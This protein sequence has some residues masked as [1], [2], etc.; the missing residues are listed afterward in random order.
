MP[1]PEEKQTPRSRPVNRRKFMAS[2]G[3]LGAAASL[4]PL[5]ALA[6]SATPEPK[7]ANGVMK[8]QPYLQQPGKD[9][10][11]VRWVTHTRCFSWVEYGQS[12]DKLDQKAVQ[13]E[14]GL[15]QADN[16]IHAITLTGLQPGKT[17]YYRAHSTAVKSLVRRKVNLGDT[18][19]S[20]V[21]SFTTLPLKQDQVALLVFNDIHDR[22][23]SFGHLMQFQEGGKKDFVLLNGD[24]FN[25][26]ESEDQVINHLLVP[27]TQQFAS[28]TPFYF[29]RGNHELHG[30]FSRQLPDY[31]DGQEHKFYYSVQ[32]GPVYALI[33]DSGESKE[34]DNEVHGGIIQ[35]FDAY[36]EAQA[37]WLAQE[38]QKKAFKEAKYRIVFVHHPLYHMNEDI[39]ANLHCRK[40]WG[41]T[42]NK[43][44]IDLM[45]SGH[46]HKAG[47]HPAEPGNHN[48][49]IVI[50]GGP[51]DG[52]RTLIQINADQKSLVLTMKNDSGKEIGSLKL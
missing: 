20:E 7:A 39:H 10:M 4:Q 21:F 1:T 36:R 47:I 27:L 45:V 23:E 9:H 5:G 32:Y 18:Q 26:E 12:P 51:A 14:D 17:Y 49:P 40:L 29:C 30:N 15:V 31:F 48:Y 34:D 19:A 13:V 46:T 2:L 11:T 35:A 25:S 28:R 24:M 22:P 43:A 42:F 41:P 33:M 8:S 6:S 50:G 16:T 52:K 44:K 3:V 37:R 38:V